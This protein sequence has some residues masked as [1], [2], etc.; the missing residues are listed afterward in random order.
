MLICDQFDMCVCML[1]LRDKIISFFNKKD[2]LLL[3]FYN[4]PVF[5]PIKVLGKQQ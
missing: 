3:F 1:H 2:F 5:I 4:G